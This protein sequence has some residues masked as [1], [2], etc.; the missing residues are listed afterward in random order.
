MRQ[1]FGGRSRR[2]QHRVNVGRGEKVTIVDRDNGRAIAKL[3]FVGHEL[4]PYG[5]QRCFDGVAAFRPINHIDEHRRPFD[6]GEKAIT[7]ANANTGAFDETGDIGEHN[8]P[9]AAR[10]NAEVRFNRRER[11]SGDFRSRPRQ[12]HQQR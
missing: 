3:W 12:R 10:K 9:L 7:Q 4:C 8:A 1:G 6:M 2:V 11:V 5:R